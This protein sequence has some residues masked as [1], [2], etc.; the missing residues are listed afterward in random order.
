MYVVGEE[1]SFYELL[2]ENQMINSNNVPNALQL[3]QLKAA[4]N[5][6]CLELVNRKQIIF[7]QDTARPYV[8]LMTRQK[9]TAWL[10]SSDLFCWRRG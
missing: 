6:R 3:D 10:G 4:L 1:G 2:P 7:H 9:L 5:K 8:S